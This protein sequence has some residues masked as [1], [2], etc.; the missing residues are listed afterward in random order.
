MVDTVRTFFEINNI[1]V[2]FV[3]GQIFFIM[4]LVIAL[5]SR[6]HSRLEL[7]RSLGWLAAFG[8]AHG[9]HE[10]G[11]VF[12]PIQA[13]YVSD[14]LIELLEML[15]VVLLAVSF[16][17][18]FQF[19]V[20]LFRERWPRLLL[21]PLAIV[22]IWGVLC[23]VP[24]LFFN[25]GMENWHCDSSILARYM[26]GFP[27]ALLSAFGLRHQAKRHIKPLD[28]VHIYRTLL[29]AGV[30][31]GAYAIAAGL[32]VSPGDFFPANWFNSTL[33]INWFGVPVPVVRSVAG[34]VM[35][36]TFI[37]ALEVFDVEIDRRIEQMEIE[38]SLTAERERISQELHDGV[39]Q[40]VY[41]AG[42]IVETIRKKV[43]HGGG[44]GHRL[45]RAMIAMN[46]AIDSLRAYMGDLRP[47]P[48]N[49]SLVAGLRKKTAD[50]RLA[51][52]MNVKLTLDMAATNS[53]DPVQTTRILAIL[54]ESLANAARHAQARHVDVR[55]CQKNGQFILTVADDGC[56]FDIDPNEFG[57]GL[58]DMRDR[59]RLL[60]GKL[61]ID[62]KPGRGTQIELSVP[63]G[64]E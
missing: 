14:R 27:G 57:Y 35:A 25:V 23:I 31:L 4:G 45:D 16:A 60:G 11:F 6:R 48:S 55:A 18:L 24:F 47:G 33:L 44:L 9:I 42:L 10:W 38:K 37:R 8:I 63:W 36:V 54:S 58:R 61:T 19:G 7:A 32:I 64:S 51:A 30:A 29:V 20:E 59:A 13:T 40:Q 17:F 34:L 21:L 22:T 53:P 43:N 62:S 56:G 3:Y 1:L 28:L 12:I 41:T 2:Y 26:L 46:E 49:I 5:Q 52:L 50:P 15:Q 39:I